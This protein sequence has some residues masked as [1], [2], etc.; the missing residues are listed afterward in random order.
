MLYLPV[1][2]GVLSLDTGQ[3]HPRVALRPTN[4]HTQT[5]LERA[6]LLAITGGRAR[7][8]LEGLRPTGDKMEFSST[9]ERWPGKITTP[10]YMSF[11]KMLSWRRALDQTKDLG[12]KNS[13]YEFYNALLPAA[14]DIVE[15][16]EIAGLPGKITYDQF[17]ASEDL[18]AWLIDCI[19]ELYRRTNKTDPKLPEPS[20][21]TPKDA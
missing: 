1:T 2:E 16:W 20:L 6:R 3:G 9:V 10:D 11:P 21:T 19:R 7:F 17:P 5:R 4:S 8:I 12:D 18:L 15:G 13:L 14:L